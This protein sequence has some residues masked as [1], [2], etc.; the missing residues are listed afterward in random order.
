MSPVELE[1]A[2]SPSRSGNVQTVPLPPPPPMVCS[3]LGPHL[4]II[5]P[6]LQDLVEFPGQGVG[7]LGRGGRKCG[8]APIHFYL[9]H[10]P[11]L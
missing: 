4:V 1:V 9:C 7:A 6:G 8:I 5:Q 11:S 2:A 3:V 10:L